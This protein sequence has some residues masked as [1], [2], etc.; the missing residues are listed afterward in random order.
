[1][2]TFDKPVLLT[3]LQTVPAPYRTAF[4]AA[5]AQRLVPAYL[6]FV[7]HTG[8]QSSARLPSI[9]S[10]VWEDLQGATLTEEELA[11]LRV[12]SAALIP[13]DEDPDNPWIPEQDTAEDAAT[14]VAYVLR[15]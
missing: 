14:A 4:A 12:E 6:N 13:E 7:K 8:G 15:C 9:L 11:A 2:L 10:R 3:Q 1:M 5:C